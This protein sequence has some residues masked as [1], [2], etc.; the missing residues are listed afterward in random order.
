[1]GYDDR[2]NEWAD[3]LCDMYAEIIDISEDYNKS[4]M[5]VMWDIMRI[6]SRGG[7]GWKDQQSSGSPS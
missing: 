6:A 3:M 2:I 1:M 4:Q 5:E 7:S